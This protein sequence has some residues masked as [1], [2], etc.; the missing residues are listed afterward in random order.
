[1]SLQSFG[2]IT[3][4]LMM[5][6]HASVLILE[7]QSNIYLSSSDL[8]LCVLFLLVSLLE[9]FMKTVDKKSVKIKGFYP[10]SGLFLKQLE[11]IEK[12][13]LEKF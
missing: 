9:W 7:T 1:M 12:W 10:I 4:P 11:K 5:E 8:F 6:A 3:T 13:Q 2:E